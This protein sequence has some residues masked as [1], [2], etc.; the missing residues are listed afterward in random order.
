MQTYC[1][2]RICPL[3]AHIDHQYGVVSGAA[4]DLGITLNYEPLDSSK[5]ILSSLDYEG[6]VAFDIEEELLR[7]QDWADY[8]RG[9]ISVLKM[10]YKLNQGL[11][12]EFKADI[13]SGGISSSSASQIAF[14]SAICK[15]NDITLSKKEMIDIVYCVEHDYMGLSVG[16]LD[17]SCEVLSKSDSLLFL[18]TLTNYH[19]IVE[20]QEFS[21]KYQF[22][23]LYSGVDRKLIHSKYN[24]RV[25]EL[26]N[27]YQDLNIDINKCNKLRDIPDYYFERNKNK[28]NEV[29]LKRSKHY[30]GEMERVKEGLRAWRHNDMTTL[31]KLMNESCLSSIHYYESGSI[32]LIDLFNVTKEVDG[33]LGTRFLGA[34]F[35]GSSLALIEKDKIDSIVHKITN[36]Y[37]L[38]HPEVMDSFKIYPV[39]L[40]DGVLL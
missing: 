17:P 26:N 21:N 1:P 20:N 29:E 35:N 9:V 3:G 12:G 16:I 27:A 5:I 14:L 10:K 8:F 34:G 32:Y 31:G 11:K 33:V 24:T 2:Y 19:Q 15:I 28:L 39:T 37:T 6:V 13:P 22:L 4:V 38:L 18:D 7:N 25:E 36:A 40:S 30:F 23:I